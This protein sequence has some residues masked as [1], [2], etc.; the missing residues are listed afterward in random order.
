MAKTRVPVAGTIGK[1]IRTVSTVPSTPAAITQAQFQSIVNAVVATIGAQSPSG[2]QPTD[3]SII[4]SIPPNVKDVAALKYNGVPVRNPDGSWSIMPLSN[5][6]GAP[7]DDGQ[8]GDPGPPGKDGPQGP[9]GPTGAAGGPIGPAGPAVW[10]QAEPGEDGPAIPGPPGPVGPQGPAGP[11]GTGGGGSPGG[12]H[13]LLDDPQQGDMGPPGPAG[14]AGSGGGTPTV[15]VP[16]SIAGLLFWF[17]ADVLTQTSGTAIPYV[18][19]SAPGFNGWGAPNTG[20]NQ[21]TIGATPLNSKN[22]LNV[23]AT[24]QYTLSPGAILPVSTIFIVMRPGAV[25]SYQTIF[26]SGT[27]NALQFTVNPSGNLELD[28]AGVAVIGSSTG[29][30]SVGT[31][32]QANVTYDSGSGAYAFRL[33]RATSGSGS[34]TSSLTSPATGVFYNPS[35]SQPLNAAVAELIIYTR[36]LTGPEIASVEAYLLAK[37]GV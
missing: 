17:Q 19:N 10:M 4:S 16:A 18:Q 3:W 1:S 22:V 23:P 34:N 14:A 21:G 24:T 29:A 5:S 12:M 13:F 7:G 32:L 36:V 15:L 28:D 8:P 20:G 37:W 11:S 35:T 9:V 2:L 33:A 31:A 27:S 30:V 6:V 26:G 25:G